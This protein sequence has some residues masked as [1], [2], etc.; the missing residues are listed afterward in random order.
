M[1]ISEIF[2]SIQG[3]GPGSGQPS[4]FIR[5][6]KCNL[7][8]AN[9]D[10]PQQKVNEWAIGNVSFRVKEHLARHASNCRIVV[11]GG[12][13]LLQQDDLIQLVDK[14]PDVPIDLETNGTISID[15]DFSKA[16]TYIV[17][18][19]KKDYCTKTP[20]VRREFFGSWRMI[21]NV[22]FKFVMGNQAWMWSEREVQDLISEFKLDP[23]HVWLMPGGAT[24]HEL[25][26]SG[27]RTWKSALKL[28]CN[29][30]D[31]LHIRNQGK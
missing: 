26:I 12:E 20:Q 28:N 29:F 3:E 18:S 5:L 14:L 25:G 16:L 23:G 10:T 4:V 7:C 1:Q 27:S 31:R 30:S 24:I 21:G 19:P 2:F 22:Y 17:V 6:A 11:T 15:Q 13:P 9:C 8:C